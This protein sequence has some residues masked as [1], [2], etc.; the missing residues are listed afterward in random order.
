MEPVC[1]IV[2]L[3]FLPRSWKRR[4]SFLSTHRWVRIRFLRPAAEDR[5]TVRFPRP[6]TGLLYG[7]DHSPSTARPRPSGYFTAYDPTTGEMVWRQIFEG[8]G[9]AGSV[10]TA[11]GVVFVGAGSNIAGYFY[12]YDA[13]TG[14]ELW[15]FNTGAGI[16]S[17]PSIYVV[18]GEEFVTVASGGGERGRRGG[19]L[20]LSFALPKS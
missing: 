5:I 13:R 1:L 20:I 10:V 6:Q 18:D 17:S 9:Q 11:G 2:P 7:G 3:T 8:Y 12:A 15:K 19:D 16:F 4:R 14:Q